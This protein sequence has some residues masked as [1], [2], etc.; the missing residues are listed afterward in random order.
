MPYGYNCGDGIHYRIDLIKE[1]GLEEPTVDWTWEDLRNLAKALTTD[2]RKGIGMHTW[3]LALPLTAEGWGYTVLRNRLPAPDTS[4]NWKWDFTTSA[5]EWAERIAW[6]RSMMFEDQS[7]LADIAMED[8]Q[9]DAQFIQ[10]TVAMANNNSTYHTTSP[11]PSVELS[12]SRA[13][14]ELGKPIEEVFGYVPHPIG[15]NG[16][17]ATSW[18]QLDTMALNPDLDQTALDK[19][20]SLHIYMMGPGIRQPEEGGLR[21]DQRPALRLDRRRHHAAL[22]TERAGGYPGDAG[23]GVGR[24]VHEERARRRQPS[25]DAVATL[26][27]S[28]AVRKPDRPIHRWKTRAIAG[29]STP[30][31]RTSWPT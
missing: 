28:A 8:D 5:E 14:D 7:I 22:Q 6:F 13:A 25:A 18:G 16:F 20:A 15:N 27:H 24:V 12:M 31:S 4:W 21:G 2:E 26:V 19:A 29:S 11:S 23:R 17:T 10:G 9:I 3:G 30:A 1:A